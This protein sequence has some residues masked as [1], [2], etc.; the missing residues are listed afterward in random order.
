MREYLKIIGKWSS[1]KALVPTS[2]GDFSQL[3]PILVEVCGPSRRK[4]GEQK[5]SPPSP[6]K[7]IERF[8]CRASTAN[9]AIKKGGEREVNDT[10]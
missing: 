3:L 2:L 5:Q 9:H 8:S 10:L 4:K 1:N 7:E 6:K